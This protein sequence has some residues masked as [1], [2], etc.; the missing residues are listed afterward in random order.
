M[1]DSTPYKINF[2]QKSSPSI[3]DDFLFCE[4]YK[5]FTVDKL[6]YIIRA[7]FFE[8]N[9]ICVKYY[10]ARDRKREDKYSILTNRY[11]AHFI[12]STC[13]CMLPILLDKY[14]SHSFAFNASR[15]VNLKMDFREQCNN[16]QR[17]R[18]YERII[19]KYVGS[20]TFEHYSFSEVSSYLLINRIGCSDV[21]LKKQSIR[22]MF[23]N[24]YE[25][26]SEISG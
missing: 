13:A 23:L 1:F 14:P 2:I 17:Y 9:V 6:K 15:T 7:E 24:L 12:F 21:E 5:F 20:K 4:I 26:E 22:N 18:I 19:T 16:N 11:N 8:N 10:V 25:F 3:S